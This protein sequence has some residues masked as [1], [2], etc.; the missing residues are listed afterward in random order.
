MAPFNI[1][2]ADVDNNNPGAYDLLAKHLA[3]NGIFWG[4]D[5][6]LH[7]QITGQKDT[8][9]TA[10]DVDK[11]AIHAGS[12]GL[13]TIANHQGAIPTPSRAAYYVSINANLL[14]R[15]DTL[16]PQADGMFGLPAVHIGETGRLESSYPGTIGRVLY[17]H[18][19]G[20]ACKPVE[21][22]AE[23]PL[24]RLWL[25]GMHFAQPNHAALALSWAV[26]TLARPVCPVFPLLLIDGQKSTG[27][28]QLAE[29]ISHFVDGGAFSPMTYTGDEGEFEKRLASK[30]GTA[31]PIL[32]VVDNVRPKRKQSGGIRSQF[33][34]SATTCPRPSLRQNYG[35]RVQPVDFP[36]VIMTMNAATI[37]HDLY[38]RVVRVV[39][40][41]PGRYYSPYPP[42]FVR[43]NRDAMIAEAMHILR[44]ID[45]TDAFTQS[46]RFGLFERIATAV[47]AR[48]GLSIDFN[49]DAHSTVDVG[50]REALGL[51]EDLSTDGGPGVTFVNMASRVRQRSEEF[52]EMYSRVLAASG[53]AASARALEAFFNEIAPRAPYTRHDGMEVYFE[54]VLV[55]R[56]KGL[57]LKENV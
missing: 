38:D 52:P 24:L 23:Y 10:I 57:V 34:A 2:T 42:A 1:L 6:W 17:A 8:R 33:L 43:D 14:A 25:S 29:A 28:S 35:K 26:T 16:V 4:T 47:A 12:L 18:F 39:C 48:L 30:V 9:V 22:S 53:V 31:G 27:K 50:V 44:S 46:T 21:F 3:E 40:T 54:P 56:R 20:R 55:E 7:L 15:A 45:T 19:G 51:M 13:F 41:N 37:E 32:A 49:P 36:L 5:R 11:L